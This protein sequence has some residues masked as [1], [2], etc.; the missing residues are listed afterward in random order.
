MLICVRYIWRIWNRMLPPGHYSMDEQKS[1]DSSTLWM[2]TREEASWWETLNLTTGRAVVHWGRVCYQEQVLSRRVG[3]HKVKGIY[4]RK[5]PFSW[6]QWN[7]FSRDKVYGYTNSKDVSTPLGIICDRYPMT[8]CQSNFL[9]L[10]C[11]ERIGSYDPVWSLSCRTLNC[12]NLLAFFRL[13][14]S[15]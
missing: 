9:R 14:W 8:T 5:W 1:N 13:H 3:R 4:G 7:R 12:T 2:T 6:H 15:S 11:F 10:H